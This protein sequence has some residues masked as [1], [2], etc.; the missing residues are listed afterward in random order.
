MIVLEAWGG[1]PILTRPP[2]RFAVWGNPNAFRTECALEIPVEIGLDL[3]VTA[4]PRFTHLCSHTKN[5]E[6]TLIVL[7]P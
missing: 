6:N 7:K 5:K 1:H 3:H 4:V 2:S